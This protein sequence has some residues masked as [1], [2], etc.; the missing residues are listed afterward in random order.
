M[1]HAFIALLQSAAGK[2]ASDM[3]VR[4][5]QSVALTSYGG[6]DEEKCSESTDR[7]PER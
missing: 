6:R 7:D 4:T 5:K 1:T 3:K 2:M